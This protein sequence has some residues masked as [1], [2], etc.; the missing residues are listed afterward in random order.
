MRRVRLARFS[1]MTLRWTTVIS[2]IALDGF[3]FLCQSVDDVAQ[4]GQ[5]LVDHGTFFEARPTRTGAV[6]A[7]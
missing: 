4:S 3:V 2:R 7:L 1:A 5:S 6:G